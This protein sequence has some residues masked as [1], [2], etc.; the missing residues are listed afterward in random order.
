MITISNLSKNFDERILLENVS[1]SIFPNERIGLTGPNG[2][3]KSTLFQIILGQMEPSS[4]T[5]QIQKGLNIGYMAQEAKYASDRTVM[6]EMTS[7]DEEIRGLLEE[8]HKL[9]DE[10]KADSSR[11]GDI[12]E[13]L[14]HK[15]I[16]ELE[17]KAEKI[18]TGLGFKEA[19]FHKPIAHLSGGWQMRTQLA[20]L[21]TYKYDLILLD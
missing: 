10:H 6:E 2:A 4:G 14:E 12:M 17:H 20:K 18:L 8:K 13:Q 1:L 9:E 5:V 7:G 16:Y 15:G 21:L 11:Y 3:G 19:E